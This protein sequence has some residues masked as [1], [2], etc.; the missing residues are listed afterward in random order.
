M[1]YRLYQHWPSAP[2]V[3]VDAELKGKHRDHCLCFSCNRF[4]PDDREKNCPRA[5]LLYSFCVLMDMTTPVYECPEFRECG[6]TF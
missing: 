2:L 4:S 6:V 3:W 1:P 5:N